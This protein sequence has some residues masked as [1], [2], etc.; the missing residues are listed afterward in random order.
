[1]TDHEVGFVDKE[2]GNGR[3]SRVRPA[4]CP[5]DCVISHIG[6]DEW[7]RCSG[8]ACL[9][10]PLPPVPVHSARVSKVPG[11]VKV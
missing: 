2:R 6:I 3:L 5:Q 10:S 7:P 4:K 8:E 11:T 9:S 1:M